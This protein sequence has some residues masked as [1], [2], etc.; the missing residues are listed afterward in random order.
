M[1]TKTSY[2]THD[3]NALDDPKCMLL[4]EQL[5]MEGYGIFWAL[6]ER[7]RQQADCRLP[8]ALIP[9]LAARLGTSETKL[10]AVIGGYGL[11]CI[12][13]DTVFFSES[14]IR[15]VQAIDGGILMRR[16]RALKAAQT[17]WQ[18]AL[19]E[20]PEAAPETYPDAQAMLKQCSSN[21]IAM[22]E[23]EKP[24]AEEVNPENPAGAKKVHLSILFNN[25][26]YIDN[27]KESGEKIEGEGG[28]KRGTRPFEKPTVEEIAAYVREKGYDVVPEAFF[29]FYESKGWKIG[30]N[31]MKNWKQAVVTWQYREQGGRRN[32]KAAETEKAAASVY[33]GCLE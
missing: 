3:A 32:G 16:E 8:L 21:A 20:A 33:D 11:F 1:D 24:I 7:L 14:L 9:A 29:A 2:F 15:R 31:P 25:K 23:H 13:A 18:K 12:E 26:D 17:R 19:P 30:K 28:K 4:V 10:K 27:N 6:V 22:L 5:G